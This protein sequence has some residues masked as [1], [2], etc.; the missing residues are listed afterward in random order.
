MPGERYDEAATPQRKY[1]EMFEITAEKFPGFENEIQG[2]YLE[3]ND[4]GTKT[5]YTYVVKE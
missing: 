5:Y 1:F 3:E 4:D 2:M